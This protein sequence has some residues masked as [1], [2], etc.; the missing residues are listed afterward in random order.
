MHKVWHEIHLSRF[1]DEN[2]A[3]SFDYDDTFMYLTGVLSFRHRLFHA[4]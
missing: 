1:D 3:M 2:D 4:H